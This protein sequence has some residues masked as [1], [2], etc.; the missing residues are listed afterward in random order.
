M[1]YRSERI[2]LAS[3]LMITALFASL[4]AC[5]EPTREEYRDDMTHHACNNYYGRCGRIGAGKTYAT[6]DE[7]IVKLKPTIDNMWPADKCDDG[8]IDE[9]QF[10]ACMD[11]VSN[12][13][14][15]SLWDW[16]SFGEQCGAANVC[17]APRS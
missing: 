13:S 15:T 11:R 14:C 2:K 5:A 7:C 17:T 10:N 8:R 12:A 3:I 1:K 16:L 9:S 4:T 6:L